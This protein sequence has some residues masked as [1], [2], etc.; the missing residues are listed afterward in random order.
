MIGMLGMIALQQRVVIVEWR[1][2]LIGWVV[3]W[4]AGGVVGG[5]D[6]AG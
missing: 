2:G 4:V 5:K 1:R 3:D 6:G